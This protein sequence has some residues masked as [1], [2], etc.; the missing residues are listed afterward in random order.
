MPLI[1]KVIIIRRVH[2]SARG[3]A[4]ASTLRSSAAAQ[5]TSSMRIPSRASNLA[6]ALR[7]K[8]HSSTLRLF[9]H[10]LPPLVLLHVFLLSRSPRPLFTI[11]TKERMARPWRK[12]KN[13]PYIAAIS[14]FVCR[15]F[16]P[17]PFRGAENAAPRKKRREKARKVING[18]V[19]ERQPRCDSETTSTGRIFMKAFS[20]RAK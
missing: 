3:R 18:R 5:R 7:R 17:P 16:P 14:S 4:L 11:V 20:P 12:M 10:P 6:R 15:R 1:G 9:L 2:R 13:T 8:Y 19:A